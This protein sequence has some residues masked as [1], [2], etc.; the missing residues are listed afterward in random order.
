M[1]R[2]SRA[3]QALLSSSSD[4]HSGSDSEEAAFSLPRRSRRNEREMHTIDK[5]DTAN[6]FDASRR[7]NIMEEDPDYFDPPSPTTRR[8]SQHSLERDRDELFLPPHNPSTATQSRRGSVAPP[9][10][11]ET[12]FHP[13]RDYFSSEEEEAFPPARHSATRRSSTNF[14]GSEHEMQPVGRRSSRPEQRVAAEEEGRRAVE[15]D[16]GRPWRRLKGWQ[17]GLFWLIVI[18]GGVGIAAG[19]TYGIKSA[20]VHIPDVLRPGSPAPPSSSSTSSTDDDVYLPHATGVSHLA[21]KGSL[22]HYIA[23]SPPSSPPPAKPDKDELFLPPHSPSPNLPFRNPTKPPSTAPQDL[24]RK[25]VPYRAGHDPASPVSSVGSSPTFPPKPRPR[26]PYP[27]TD[28]STSDSSDSDAAAPLQK[29]PSTPPPPYKPIRTPSNVSSLRST[30]SRLR[31]RAPPLSPPAPLLLASQSAK[32]PV[33]LARGLQTPS[34][35]ARLN[36]N[37]PASLQQRVRSIG[38]SSPVATV[39]SFANA[40]LHGSEEAK[41]EGKAQHSRLVGRNKFIHEFQKHKVLPQHVELYKERIAAYYAGIHSSPE[42]EARLTGSWEVVVGEVDMFVHIFEYEG[43]AGFEKTKAA[44]RASQ[45]HL[46]FFNHE[47]LPLIQSRTS[48]LNSEFKFFPVAPAAE[49]GGVYELRTY[50]LK[51]GHLLEWEQ[52]WRVGLEARIATGHSPVGAWFTQVGPLHRVSHLWNYASLE[53]RAEQRARSWQRDEWSETV[54]RTTRLTDSMRTD[55]LKPLD[56]SPL[57]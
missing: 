17:R 33:A 41:A 22:P 37:Q 40:L 45:G 53:A 48:S 13:H 38:T 34:A 49:L 51:P 24:R 18:C 23:Y 31:Q 52:S 56:F 46:E 11:H 54:I 50:D 12:P 2:Q 7:R 28:S 15:V 27:T 55:I 35:L 6:P 20:D 26:P 39:T 43:L 3:R 9:H 16:H 10:P 44:I 57:R 32:S 8:P 1:S 5:H 42:F 47:I 30:A 4:E 29:Y 25:P 14:R 19:V 21:W 36:L